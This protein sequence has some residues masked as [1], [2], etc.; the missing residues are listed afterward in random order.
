MGGRKFV[1]NVPKLAHSDP[2]ADFNPSVFSQLFKKKKVSPKR[3]TFL[4]LEAYEQK[5]MLSLGR[6]QSD[7]T[8]SQILH[9][10]SG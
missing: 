7:E 1:L 4:T 9:F 3:V 8:D 2:R 6:E 5:F 10:V